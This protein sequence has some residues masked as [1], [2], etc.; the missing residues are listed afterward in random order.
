M[1]KLKGSGVSASSAFVRAILSPTGNR[2]HI[3]KMTIR[4]D[5]FFDKLD[6]SQGTSFLQTMPD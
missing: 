5:K 6:F 1:Y 3:P 4:D 2:G